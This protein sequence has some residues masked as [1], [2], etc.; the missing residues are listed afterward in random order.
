M[1]VEASIITHWKVQ[2]RFYKISYLCFCNLW[3]S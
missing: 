3:N 2:S 1:L